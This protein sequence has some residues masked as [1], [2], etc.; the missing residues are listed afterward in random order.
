MPSRLQSVYRPTAIRTVNDRQPFTASW[1]W[2]NQTGSLVPPNWEFG[3]AK[4]GERI[5]VGLY[6]DY[7]TIILRP[8]FGPT[9]ALAEWAPNE[10]RK[11]LLTIWLPAWEIAGPSPQ[12][13]RGVT[14][15]LSVPFRGCSVHP[16]L[17]SVHPPRMLASCWLDIGLLVILFYLSNSF[18]PYWIACQISRQRHK[19]N[20]KGGVKEH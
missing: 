15:F 19:R 16:P 11:R 9:C 10:L 5:T 8:S 17:C 1:V 2:H 12:W 7:T 20:T 14:P 6:F 18:C 4:L 13:G 3:T